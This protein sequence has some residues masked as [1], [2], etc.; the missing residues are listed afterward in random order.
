MTKNVLFA[1]RISILL[2]TLF[3]WGIGIGLSQVPRQLITTIPEV[4]EDNDNPVTIIYDA[5]QGNGALSFVEGT[6]YAHTGIVGVSGWEYTKDGLSCPLV[7]IGD[8]KWKLTMPQGI[9][10][11][12]GVTDNNKSIA[13]IE[14][15]FKNEAGDKW[16]KNYDGSNIAVSVGQLWSVQPA[17]LTINEPLVITFNAAHSTYASSLKGYTGDVYAH[18]GVTTAEGD[19]KHG[20]DWEDNSPK[21][22]L[23]PIGADK[24]QLTIPDGIQSFYGTSSTEEVLKMNFVFR[25]TDNKQSEDIFIPVYPNLCTVSKAFPT[26]TEALAFVFDLSAGDEGLKDAAIT[27]TLYAHT[28]VTIDGKDWQLATDWSTPVEQHKLTSLGGSKWKLEMPNG[29]RTFYNVPEGKNVQRVSFVI[30]N[31]NGSA[32][33]KNADGSDIFVGV[34]PSSALNVRFDTPKKN[35]TVKQNEPIRYIVSASATADIVVK[36]EDATLSS[37]SGTSLSGNHSFAQAGTYTLLAQATAGETVVTD[38]LIV[39]VEA[40]TTT[41][42]KPANTVPGINY[43]AGDATTVTLAL[44]APYKQSAYVIGDFN[45]WTY[46]PEYQMKRDND[47]ETFWITL[48]G[49]TS[50]T[51]YAYQYVID[52]NICIADPY[53]EKV[54]DPWNDSYI[55]NDVYPNLKAYPTDANGIVSVFQT[56]QSEYN[57][58]TTN[59]TKPQKKDL[60]IYEIHLRDF[61]SE[62]TY[63]AAQAKLP[64]LK[65]LGINAIELMPTNEFEGNDSWG[66]NPSFFFAVD[67]A[68]GTKDDFKA[69]I[70][71]CHAQ[72]I[73]VIIDLVLNHSFGQSPLL[74]LYQDDKGTPLMHSPW[75]NVKSNIQNPGLQW[76][77]DFNHESFYTRSFVDRVNTHWLTEFKVDGIRYDFTKG[78]SNTPFEMASDEWA[79]AYDGGRIYNLTRMKGVIDQV[80]PGTYVICEHLTNYDE[81]HELGEAGFMMWRNVNHS[82]CQ[83]AMGHQSE[84]DLSRMYEWTETNGMPENSLV[85]YMESH[86]EERMAFGAKTYGTDPIKE[87]N[88]IRMKQ[89]ATSTAFF[90]T[91]PGPKMIW[92]FGELGYD[93]SIN[94]GGRTGKKP[95]KWDYYDDADRKYLFDVYSKLLYL[96]KHYPELFCARGNFN[97]GYGFKWNVSVDSWSGGR[98][99]RS[100]AGNKSMVI[101]GNFTGNEASCYG[102]FTHTGTWYDIMNGGIIEVNAITQNITVPAHEFRLYLNFDPGYRLIHSSDAA[103]DLSAETNLKIRS[104]GWDNK[105]LL[106]ASTTNNSIK[107]VDMTEAVIEAKNIDGMLQGCNAMTQLQLSHLNFTGNPLTGANP[108]CLVYVPQGT[109][110]GNQAMTKNVIAASTALTDI[111]IDDDKPFVISSTF[112]A[113]N[114]SYTRSFAGASKTGGWETIC[115]PFGVTEVNEV[116]GN[117]HTNIRPV[118]LSQTGDFWLKE[119]TSSE[120]G[121]VNFSNVDQLNANTPYLI[122]FPGKDWGTDYLDNWKVEFKGTSATFDV[123]Q[124]KKKTSSHYHYIG[125][126]E[127]KTDHATTPTLYMLDTAANSFSKTAGNTLK[128]FR[129]YFIDTPVSDGVSGQSLIIGEGNNGTTGFIEF[130]KESDDFTTILG[131]KGEIVIQMNNPTPIVIYDAN[132]TL[133]YKQTSLQREQKIGVPAGIY[134]V[135]SQK[136]IVY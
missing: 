90:L 83:V 6:V 11:F 56:G 106:S 121:V 100:Q 10:Q 39:N 41:E 114:V 34:Y 46:A 109:T 27:E 72:G 53:T 107:S 50:G 15:V 47:G 60:V 125:T 120:E 9:R 87:N 43:N 17:K 18:T 88:S 77:A 93:F 22:K 132:G 54:L 20:T 91:V 95:I 105:T 102:E 67:K 32:Q 98:L 71:E 28:G 92:Q 124:E 61:T 59:F 113:G 111:V 7:S 136:I 44:Q 31:A 117:I 2:L 55:T 68:Y 38:Q 85:G 70:D 94:E 1:R 96:K 86:D 134:V 49:L 110:N 4:I 14:F 133:I 99:I 128:P 63:K 73:A 89:L 108:N 103:T 116:A 33:S 66:Y 112:T 75:Y 36:S 13:K 57:W 130:E 78:F 21:Y 81:E 135:N 64:Y 52:G 5:S 127:T 42:N 26:E 118:T 3:Y 122:A 129:S 119:Y 76:G 37:I 25:G 23:Q 82:Y 40:S 69:F 24:W 45:D 48:T 30:R 29:I 126:Y 16:G 58:Q 35:I 79:N 51:E 104:G 123:N 101:I 12:Y 8:N 115:L 97:E 84:S 62:G 19:W 74:H 80:S 65:E 131:G